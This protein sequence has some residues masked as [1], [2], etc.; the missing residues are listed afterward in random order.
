MQ[1]VIAEDTSQFSLRE[2]HKV[3]HR[4]QCNRACTDGTLANVAELLGVDAFKFTIASA[5]KFELHTAS[6]WQ[7]HR[8]W[9]IRISAVVIRLLYT[10]ACLR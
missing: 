9:T 10:Y 6:I 7:G 1:R 3:G 5:D 8:R 4:E 2:L